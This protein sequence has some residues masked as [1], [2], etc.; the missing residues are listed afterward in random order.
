MQK[1]TSM[2][3]ERRPTPTTVIDD[4]VATLTPEWGPTVRAPRV[5]VVIPAMN[6]AANLPY[7]LPRLPHDLHEVILVDGHSTD[8]TAEVAR[9]IYPGIRV[10]GQD[11]QGKGNALQCGFEAC[12]GDIIVMLDAD[13]STDAAEIPRFVMALCSGADFVKGSRFASGGGSADIT[14][15][16]RLG[17]WALNALVNTLFHTRY[18]D[19]CY[20]YNAFWA[21]CL[22]HID[23]DCDGFE[24]ETL[25]NIRCAK[26]GLVV[27]EVPSYEGH[28]V[29][30]VSNL[31]AARDGLRVFRTILLERRMGPGGRMPERPSVPKGFG[32]DGVERR[33]AGRQSNLVATRFPAR[34]GRAGRASFG[35]RASDR[36]VVSITSSHPPRPVQAAMEHTLPCIAPLTWRS[37]F[38]SRTVAK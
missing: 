17:N 23:V 5:S 25:I 38:S 15:L 1:T 33:G 3:A 37:R 30:G 10:I 24:V 13:G 32:W 18:T 20:G 6:E 34:T 2:L 27:H 21:Y 29:H 7:V 35:R 4:Q 36:S 26:A 11:G 22:P 9:A 8:G 16:R 12:T 28:R 14:R 19:L 31:N